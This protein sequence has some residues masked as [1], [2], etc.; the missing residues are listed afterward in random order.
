M[1][2]HDLDAIG[3]PMV[4]SKCLKLERIDPACNAMQNIQVIRHYV[5]DGVFIK[6]HH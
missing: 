6:F 3:V 5:E 2:R 1:L 4:A